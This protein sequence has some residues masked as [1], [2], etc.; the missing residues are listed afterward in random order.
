MA[1]SIK[2]DEIF[3]MMRKNL[4]DAENQGSVNFSINNLYA[5]IDKLERAFWDGEIN[6]SVE[7]KEQEQE[8]IKKEH[9][10]KVS[11]T[12]WLE[13]LKMY[14]AGKIEVFKGAL[15]FA[16]LALKSALLING[17]AAVALLANTLANI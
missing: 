13:D 17:G 7:S 8:K 3:R 14:N 15:K 10:Y 6:N 1:E 11:M 9:D 2:A 4:G 16:E 5:W 12:Q